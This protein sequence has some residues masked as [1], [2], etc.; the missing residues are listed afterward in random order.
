MAQSSSYSKRPLE[1]SDIFFGSKFSTNRTVNY[2]AYAVVDYFNSNAKINIFGQLSYKFLTSTYGA[3]S[4][5]FQ[6]GG[7]NNTSFSS[8]TEIIVSQNDLKNVPTN[9][10][11]SYLINSDIVI[12]K[13]G[14][15]DVFGHY[16]LLDVTL[17]IPGFYK[18]T[19]EYIGGF[20]SIENE[21]IYSVANFAIGGGS[22]TAPTLQE[23]T[24]QGN[25]T[26]NN[27]ISSGGFYY[28]G[29]DGKYISLFDGGFYLNTSGSGFS[30]LDLRSDNLTFVRTQQVQDKDGT[31]AYLDDIPGLQNLQQTMELGNSYNQTI[32]DYSYT[33]QFDEGANNFIAYVG[34]NVT[35]TVSYVTVNPNE[36]RLETVSPTS[37][38]GNINSLGEGAT[39]VTQSPN[40]INK[41]IV[42]IRTSGSISDQANFEVQ[43]N[44]PAGTYKL[45]TL[46]DIPTTSGIPHATASGTDTYTATVTGVTAYNDADAYLIRFTNGNTTSAT[47]NINGLG[48]RALYRNND[49][50]LIGGDIISG[51]EMLCVYNSTTSRFQVIGTAPNSLFSYVTN[52]DSVTLTKGMPVYAF[53]G[54][55]DRM[56]VKRAFNTSDTTSAQTVGL[57]LSTS[58]APN[59]K[60]LIM[61]Q[62]LLDGLS[63]LPTGT[64]SDGDAVYLGATAGTITNVKP[65]A[66]N[67]LVYLGTVTT[68]SN[69]SAGRMYVRVQNGYELQELHNVQ[70]QSPTLKDTLWYDDTVSPAQWKTASIPTI[71]GYTPGNNVGSFGASFDGMGS[72]VLINSRAFFRMPKAGTITEWSIVAEGTSPTATFDVWRIASGTALPTVANTIFGT[73]PALATGNAIVSTTMTGWTTSFNANDIFCINVDACA[74]ATELQLLFKVIYS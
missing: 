27:V 10:F 20:G 50:V 22:T 48:A 16:K 55:G 5:F 56:T 62:G 12:A 61:M 6:A 42:P 51:G 39:L 63:I 58:I 47:L 33:L 68:A 4:I 45:A 29:L 21:A 57:V 69:G 23:V 30:H 36:S 53:G 9:N 34:N 2:A 65:F 19:L 8:I 70:A 15:H 46:D 1:D 17:D 32:G 74:N 31:F 18:L 11:L 41:V 54:T 43:N 40:G 59:Q 14:E 24:N 28:Q 3:S 72:F 67:H 71:L 52:D 35:S 38:A 66:P 73:K 13:Q 7:G 44:K 26:T 49:G 60:G 37:A 25:T 64:W